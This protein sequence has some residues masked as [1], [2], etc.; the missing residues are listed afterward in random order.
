M[1]TTIPFTKLKPVYVKLKDQKHDSY[2]NITMEDLKEAFRTFATVIVK[3]YD[4]P[5]VLHNIN[6]R[7]VTYTKQK[8]VSKTETEKKADYKDYKLFMMDRFNKKQLFK[9]KQDEG[10]L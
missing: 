7:V 8:K 4:A 5:Y 6:P 1:E 10:Q 2:E 9:I 3:L